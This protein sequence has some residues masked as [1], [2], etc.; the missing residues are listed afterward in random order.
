M[1]GDGNLVLYDRNNTPTW[2]SNTYQKGV[3]PFRLIMQD[4][5]NL[6]LYDSRN[7]PTW[8]TGTNGK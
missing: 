1:Q 3:A 6:V 5:G 7:T 4:D 8:A 2:S